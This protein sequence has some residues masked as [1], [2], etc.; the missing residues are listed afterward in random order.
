M[1]RIGSS[2]RVSHFGFGALG[3][4]LCALA[5]TT[6][7]C[8]SSTPGSS[9]TPSGAGGSAGAGG[10]AASAGTSEG[11]TTSGT[12]DAASTGTGMVWR[13][14]GESCAAAD[15]CQKFTCFCVKGGFSGCGAACSNQACVSG[16]TDC[17][18]ICNGL[19]DTVAHVDPVDSCN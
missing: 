19:M 12:S 2:A 5:A 10:D 8:G 18:D 4:L 7:G 11:A 17:A 15:E 16:D 1:N 6:V 9:G 13:Q 14:P 3:A